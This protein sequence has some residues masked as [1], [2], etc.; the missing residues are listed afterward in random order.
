MMKY[1]YGLLLLDMSISKV[2]IYRL[3]ILQQDYCHCYHHYYYFYYHK[4]CYTF[5]YGVFLVYSCFDMAPSMSTISIYV[6]IHLCH[7]DS[8]FH[9]N[10]PVAM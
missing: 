5:F 10:F 4:A 7:L 9:E 1:E 6:E 2:Q 8:Y 3:H